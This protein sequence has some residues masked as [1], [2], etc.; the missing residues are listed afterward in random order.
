MSSLFGPFSE[1][2]KHKWNVGV[3]RGGFSPAP[4]PLPPGAGGGMGGGMN[5][6]NSLNNRKRK[7]EDD[8]SEIYN[9]IYNY[10]SELYTLLIFIAISS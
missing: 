4:S 2:L 10:T 3:G 9:N 5:K 8:V 1:W 7:L 6:K